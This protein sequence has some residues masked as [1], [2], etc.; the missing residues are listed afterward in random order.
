MITKTLKLNKSVTVGKIVYWNIVAF[1][2]AVP[3]KEPTKVSNK[4]VTYACPPG[5]WLNPGN[6]NK[7]LTLICLK[8]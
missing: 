1:P 5:T 6:T 2:C 4:P 7:N 3:F 8:S